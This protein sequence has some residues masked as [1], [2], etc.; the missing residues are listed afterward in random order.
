MHY[1]PE[2]GMLQAFAWA[3]LVGCFVGTLIL[4]T[5]KGY[6]Y[7]TAAAWFIVTMAVPSWLAITFRSI[8]LDPTMMVG[9][10]VILMGLFRPFNGSRFRWSPIDIS[11][12]SILVMCVVSDAL[13]RLLI[14]G[15]VIQLTR[16][17][18]IPY[19]MGRIF[20]ASY[21]SP[22]RLMP[23]IA[24][25]GMGLSMYALV[26]AFTKIN[27]VA[28]MTGMVWP[29]LETSE[30][31]RWGIKRAQGNTNHPIYFGM[32]MVMLL[33]WL[34][35]VARHRLHSW[36]AALPWVGGAAGFVSVSRSAQISLLIVLMADQFFRRPVLRL[37]ILVLAIIG[38]IMFMSF[39]QEVLDSLGRY[40]GEQ[41]P[42]AD[43][44]VIYGETYDYTGT[45]HRDLLELAYAEGIEQAEWV[46]FGTNMIDM[47]KDP[48]LDKRFV[49]ID[50]DY[51]IHY[52]S[53]GYLGVGSLLVFE[54]ITSLYLIR[55]AFNRR[56]PRSDLAAG[57]C[58]SFIAVILVL[59]GV[60]WSSDF[61]DM[62][63]FVAGLTAGWTTTTPSSAL[64]VEQE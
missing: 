38:G 27:V 22:R 26:E 16:V 29:L 24:A 50:N 11:V 40:A 54:L 58:G 45:R 36:W 64:I 44:V 30:G 61:S 48:Y 34:L 10:A 14:P 56:D 39:R 9:I 46:G 1:R 3:T 15:T 63:L 7:G 20:A 2:V 53:Y 17:W 25:L 28:K 42:S 32:L 5:D 60:T 57:L 33:P 62:W 49:S 55:L 43:K 35:W 12:L 51:L 4:V 13:N 41:D 19:L 47:P 31:F 37:P 59:R 23:L 52:L 8:H 6:R 18:L 21:D